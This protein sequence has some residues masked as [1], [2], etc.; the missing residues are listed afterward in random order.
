MRVIDP[1]HLYSLAHLDGDGGQELRFVK[2]VGDRYPGNAPP[3]YEGTTLQEVLRALIDRMEYVDRQ[4]P[5]AHNR[6]TTRHLRE[7][8][9]SLEVRAAE[10]RGDEHAADLIRSWRYVE[11]AS[12]C[13]GCGHVCCRRPSCGTR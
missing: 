2:R 7:A 1:G 3:P 4:A 11:L 8:L 12:T 6:A 10:A 5:C 13:A 9:R